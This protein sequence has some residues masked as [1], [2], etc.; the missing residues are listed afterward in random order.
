[1]GRANFIVEEKT[2]PPRWDEAGGVSGRLGKARP[3]SGAV[4]HLGVQ[5]IHHARHHPF[6]LRLVGSVLHPP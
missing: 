1:M 2:V 5:E 4:A 3:G 6:D